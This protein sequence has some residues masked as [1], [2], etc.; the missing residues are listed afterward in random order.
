MLF[1][2]AILSVLLVISLAYFFAELK[3]AKVQKKQLQQFTTDIAQNEVQEQNTANEA[4]NTLI[5]TLQQQAKLL[6][7]ILHEGKES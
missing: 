3:K 2:L 5:Q 1:L 4:T 7:V 6:G